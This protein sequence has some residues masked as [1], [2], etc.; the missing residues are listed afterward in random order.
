[1]G[2][3]EGTD[4][5]DALKAMM[6]MANRVRQGGG[7]SRRDLLTDPSETVEAWRTQFVRSRRLRRCRDHNHLLG[8]GG[9]GFFEQAPRRWPADPSADAFHRANR[10]RAQIAPG[11]G[12]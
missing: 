6:Q 9:R 8:S 1:M 3:C 7:L 5:V 4:Q 2:L 11:A 10:S 12:R